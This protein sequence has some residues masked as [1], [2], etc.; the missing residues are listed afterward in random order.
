MRFELC[1][2]SGPVDAFVTVHVFL[3]ASLQDSE[4]FFTLFVRES[5]ACHSVFPGIGWLHL[6]VAF[7]LRDHGLWCH[8]L[9]CSVSIVCHSEQ[10][11]ESASRRQYH[12]RFPG[13]YRNIHSYALGGHLGISTPNSL[14]Y[15]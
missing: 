7:T 9:N 4:G 15:S 8:S 6:S 14:A 5:H 13:R 12:S 2:D 10:S 11:E 3:K 1:P